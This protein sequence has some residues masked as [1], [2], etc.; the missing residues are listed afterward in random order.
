MK[1]NLKI[2]AKENRNTFGLYIT[3]PD[4]TVIEMAAEAGFDFVRIDLEHFLVDPE[5]VLRMISTANLLS[6]SVHVR[7]GSISEITRVLEAGADGVIVPHISTKEAAL[8]A[9]NAVKFYPL[10][11]R[12][13]YN[14][15]RCLR[16][17]GIPLSEY[18]EKA[19]DSVLLTVQIEDKAGLSHIDEILSIPGIDMVSSGKSDL[20]QSLGLLGQSNH[21]AVLEAEELIAE[22]AAVHQVYPSLL[23]G[24]ESRMKR[25]IEKGV[26][27][28]TI[29][30]DRNLLMQGMKSLRQKQW[31]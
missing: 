28:F 13:M 4:P 20:S 21:P 1:K 9:V 16:Y 18:M 2:E 24:N 26:H 17:G 31:P 19:N 5:T 8:E 12:G 23:V 6:L 30:R 3:I 10:G 27:S 7:V 25:L 15:Y 14:G 29:G 11:E 22:R